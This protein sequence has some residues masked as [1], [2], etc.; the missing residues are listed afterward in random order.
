MITGEVGSLLLSGAGGTT[1]T[2][3]ETSRAPT[4]RVGSDPSNGAAGSYLRADGTS[5]SGSNRRR[6]GRRRSE[7]EAS[8]LKG[9]CSFAAV[10]ACVHSAQSQTGEGGETFVKEAGKATDAPAL[11]PRG[12]TGRSAGTCVS[13]AEPL[14]RAWFPNHTQEGN[15]PKVGSAARDHVCSKA[16]IIP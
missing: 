7:A 14:Y 9:P 16:H 1:C 2:S 10:F 11:D 3:S 4:R 13:R 6:A 12:Q 8:S 15:G 5:R